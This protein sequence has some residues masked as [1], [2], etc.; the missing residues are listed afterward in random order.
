MNKIDRLSAARERIAELEADNFEL[1]QMYR[2]VSDQLSVALGRVAEM[3]REKAQ[4]IE[5]TDG[6]PPPD[7]GD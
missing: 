6:A 7:K 4:E 1:W 2:D 3:E 5:N